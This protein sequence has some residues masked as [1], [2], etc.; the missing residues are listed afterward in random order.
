M[1]AQSQVQCLLVG[2]TII[3]LLTL[4]N[5]FCY[6]PQPQIVIRA[7]QLKFFKPQMRSSY[8]G[9]NI[10]MRPTSGSYERDHVHAYSKVSITPDTYKY[11]LQL[12]HCARNVDILVIFSFLP[13]ARFI[14]VCDLLY[15]YLGY[16]E[17]DEADDR[18]SGRLSSPRLG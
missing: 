6:A 17:T 10:V 11:S 4:A 14:N 7:P 9:Y 12:N 5:T 16:K 3:S 1:S 2:S 15:D 8:F 13:V 18:M